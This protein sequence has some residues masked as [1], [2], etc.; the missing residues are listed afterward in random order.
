MKWTHSHYRNGGSQLLPTCVPWTDVGQADH[1]FYQKF[2]PFLCY[3]Q[4][5]TRMAFFITDG[6][7]ISTL[8]LL[9]NAHG[10]LFG[11]GRL[12]DTR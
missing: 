4:T 10:R 2:M 8:K 5:F 7:L 6:I 9:I 3:M 12:L 1:V 11:L